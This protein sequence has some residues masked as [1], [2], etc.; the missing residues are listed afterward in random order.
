MKHAGGQRKHSKKQTMNFSFF[1]LYVH[2][3]G[4]CNRLSI[5]FLLSLSNDRLA[6]RT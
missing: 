6:F 5:Q 3:C 4:I 1:K 2:L